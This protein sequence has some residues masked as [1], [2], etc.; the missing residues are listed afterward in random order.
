MIPPRSPASSGSNFL[1]EWN[2][3]TSHDRAPSALHGD[4]LFLHETNSIF[5]LLAIILQEVA[6]RAR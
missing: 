4:A 5:I 3:H 6:Q 1:G 2:C